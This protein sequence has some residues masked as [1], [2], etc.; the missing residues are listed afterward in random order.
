MSTP[1]PRRFVSPCL[2]PSTTPTQNLHKPSLLIQTH[3]SDRSENFKMIQHALDVFLFH[4]T[5]LKNLWQVQMELLLLVLQS[6]GE[7]I[8]QGPAEKVKEL[9]TQLCCVDEQTGCMAYNTRPIG[10]DFHRCPGCRKSDFC[11][12]CCVFMMFESKMFAGFCTL[13][14]VCV[15]QDKALK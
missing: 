10:W 9:L 14:F 11:C 3:K 8:Y 15:L 4:Y 6:R 12:R 13:D 5:F 2:Q 7:G 1:V